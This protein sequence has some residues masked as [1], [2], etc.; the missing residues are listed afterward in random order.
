MGKRT[1]PA[2]FFAYLYMQKKRDS[3]ERRA[4]G[5]TSP[6]AGAAA[7]RT[8]S[9][10]AA[11][12]AF[13]AAFG[14]FLVA[15]PYHL[16]RRE[17]LTLFL[18]DGDYIRQTYRGAGWLAA[19]AADFLEQFFRLPVVGPLVV[20]LLLT[21]IGAVVYRIC[22]HF[23]GRWPSLAVA[24]VF[25]L[26]SFMRETDNTFITRYTIVVL[27]YL[28][29]LLL[30]LQAR[31]AWLRAGAAALLLAAGAWALGSPFHKY[32]GRPWG[33]P[34]LDYER[35]VALDT[36]VARE[37]WDKVLK[38]SEKDLY[39][40]EAS[41]CYDLAHAMKGDLGDALFNHSQ[42]GP[43]DLLLR[44][45]TDRAAFSNCLAGEAWYQLGDMTVAEQSAVIALQG[46]PKHTGSR[47]IARLAMVNL[48]SGEDAAAQKYL[49]MLG[50]T[51]FYGQ[52][53]RRMM[54]GNR[55]DA[56]EARLTAARNTLIQRDFIH[57]S[58]NP[59]AVLQALLEADSSN[60][61]ALNYLLC[62]DLMRF[63]LEGFME[64]Y[65]QDMARGHIYDE[66]VLIWLGQRDALYED[67]AAMYG[68]SPSLVN[69]MD[70]FLRNPDG[71]KDTYW[72]YY[73]NALKE[74]ER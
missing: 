30:E 39:M 58:D 45:S 74:S 48:L 4:G 62:F 57:Q 33:V 43:Y 19:F 3:R 46:S 63:D 24:A 28:S 59:K 14:F 60:T 40:V 25:Y 50:K 36:E 27:G 54:P 31:R 10:M 32:Y 71:Y 41:Y 56:T 65:D 37:N 73:L 53:A 12:A 66:A 44:V 2:F 29:L 5:I 69:K 7:G 20:A 64:D 11:V 38:L 23:M 1:I 55:D 34:R 22:R 6:A 42:S 18:F 49:D 15:Y 61:L 67:N 52:S 72:Y 9:V 17:Q 13:V 68:I 21:A 8:L 26:W 16:M 70:W 35:M 51:L 47:F